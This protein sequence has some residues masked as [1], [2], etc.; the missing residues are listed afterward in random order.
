[1]G[2]NIFSFA[3]LD[4]MQTKIGY[5]PSHDDEP[6]A[7]AERSQTHIYEYRAYHIRVARFEE[8]VA[9]IKVG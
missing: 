8:L 5:Y 2:E 4:D 9:G 1:M 3:D 7:I 6:Q